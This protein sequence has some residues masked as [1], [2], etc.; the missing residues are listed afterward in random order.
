L[1]AEYSFS[2]TVEHFNSTQTVDGDDRVMGVVDHGAK[3][4][5]SLPLRAH[6]FTEG[7]PKGHEQDRGDSQPD[8]RPDPG[9]GSFVGGKREP[10]ADCQ[11]GEKR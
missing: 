9:S 7:K 1:E 4:F 10:G 3:P 2:C 11:D 6:R 5:C 8:A